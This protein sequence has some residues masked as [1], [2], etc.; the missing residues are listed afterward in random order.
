MST[1]HWTVGMVHEVCPCCLAEMNHSIILPE[2]LVKK[3]ADQ[4]NEIN[5]K[6]VGVSDEPCKDCQ[7]NIN[8]GY[9]LLVGIDANRSEINEEGLVNFKEAYRTGNSIWL[10]FDVIREIL[11]VTDDNPLYFVDDEIFSL[12]KYDNNR[13]LLDV[14]KENQV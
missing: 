12:M 4:I 2:K 14:I 5:G 11:G 13:S 9:R 10:K 1:D 8:K 6:A 7:E 3:T